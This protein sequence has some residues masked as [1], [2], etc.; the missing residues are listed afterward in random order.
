MNQ[1]KIMRC[2]ARSVPRGICWSSMRL[3]SC[4]TPQRP[5]A[6]DKGIRAVSAS[7]ERK[8]RA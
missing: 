8:G 2:A 4:M 5:R 7:C 3:A 6:V 1:K